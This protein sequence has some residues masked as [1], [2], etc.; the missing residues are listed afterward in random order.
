MIHVDERILFERNLLALAA[1]DENLCSRLSAAQTSHEH[2][3]FLESRRGEIIPAIVQLD[4]TARPLHSLVEPHREALRVV[5]TVKEGGLLVLFGLGGGYIA[6]AALERKDVQ[7][8]IVVDFGIDGI[9]ELLAS[10]EYVRLF[11][12]SRFRLLIDPDENTLR[13]ILYS[14]YQPALFGGIAVLPLRGRVDADKQKYDLA[15]ETIMKTIEGIS[16][17]YS[18]QAYFGKRWFANAIR[19]ILRSE[20]YPKPLAPIRNVAITAAGP[21]LELQIPRLRKKRSELYLLATDTSL[22]ALLAAELI[23][24]AVIS[25]DCQ[26]ISYYHFMAGYPAEVPLFL[27]LASPPVV[28]S[29][30]PEPRF[31]SGGHPLTVYATRRWRSFPRIDTSGGNVSYA[32][33]SLAETLGAQN[34][35]LYGADF[36]YPFGEP[37]ARGTYIH[38]YFQAM[39]NRISPLE[40]HFM[41]FVFR[42][43]SLKLEREENSWRYETKPLTGYRQKLESLAPTL[44]A[45]IRAIPGKG[46]KLNFPEPKNT[47]RS[48]LN[49]FVAGKTIE[50]GRQFLAK[51]ADAIEKLPS[52]ENSVASYIQALSADERDVLTT[53]LPAAAAIRRRSTEADAEKMLKSVKAYCLSELHRVLS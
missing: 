6:E 26:H 34:I 22:P 5:S 28:A 37:Y 12:D 25:I 53:L 3:R 15:T 29:R 17:D 30:S 33:V 16:D 4:G 35:E 10:K 2:Y 44:R 9:A 31:F 14:I 42:N 8:L 41:H 51:Y 50:S 43:D 27:D 24:D 1:I 39:Q 45:N 49:L 52:M 23:P 47:Q 38:P 19:N 40:A 13:N 32:A 21:S 36:S 46:T 20:T 48:A 18:V 11:G 7:A